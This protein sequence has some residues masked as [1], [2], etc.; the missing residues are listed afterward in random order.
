MLYNDPDL[1]ESGLEVPRVACAERIACGWRILLSFLCIQGMQ[2]KLVPL[3][4]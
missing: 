2:V 3:F 1:R 4:H